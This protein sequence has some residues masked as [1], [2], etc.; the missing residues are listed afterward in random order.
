[1]DKKVNKTKLAKI[2]NIS[3]QSLYQELALYEKGKNTKHKEVFDMAF[4]GNYSEEE[5]IKAA[6]ICSNK[7][8]HTSL[9]YNKIVKLEEFMNEMYENKDGASLDHYKYKLYRILK[10]EEKE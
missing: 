9:S 5:M 10:K 8:K 7:K 3:R 2:L 6:Y 1:M 4:S